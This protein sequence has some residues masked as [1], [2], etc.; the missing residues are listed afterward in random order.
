MMVPGVGVEPT[1]GKSPRDFKSRT[2]AIPSARHSGSNTSLLSSLLQDNHFGS[3]VLRGAGVSSGVS[4][5]PC[6]GIQFLDSGQSVLWS[7]MG[8]PHG[9][10][11]G[12][13]PHKLLYGANVHSG[14]YKT[15][16]KRVPE[17]VPAERG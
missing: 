14:H 12:F 3:R 6:G 16:G 17:A 9:H 2:S 15:A 1:R 8:I 13:V 10:G 7:E 5:F 4:W 11:D